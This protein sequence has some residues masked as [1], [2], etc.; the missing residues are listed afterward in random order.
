MSGSN[1]RNGGCMPKEIRGGGRPPDRGLSERQQLSDEL[2]APLDLDKELEQ[3]RQQKEEDWDRE[4]TLLDEALVGSTLSGRFWAVEHFVKFLEESGLQDR[5]SRY[6]PMIYTEFDMTQTR[7]SKRIMKLKD[8]RSIQKR[9]KLFRDLL[10]SI[11]CSD[12]D[13]GLLI[14]GLEKEP[15]I[16]SPH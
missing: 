4:L 6:V 13:L 1:V 15:E 14:R 2:G 9:S 16:G 8:I 5:L 11:G 10:D 12:A 3:E 7:R